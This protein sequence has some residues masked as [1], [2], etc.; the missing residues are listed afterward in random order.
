MDA[1]FAIANMTTEFGGMGACFEA[2]EATASWIANRQHPEHRERGLYFKADPGA[3][4][5]DE[6]TIDLSEVKVTVALHLNPNDVV[7]IPEKAGMKLDGC[8]IGACTTT[9]GELILGALVLE[10]GLHEVSGPPHAASDALPQ[11]V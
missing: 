5:V 1:R 4:Y 8:F 3:Q 10:A 11:E 6:R 7:P 9:E 2:D